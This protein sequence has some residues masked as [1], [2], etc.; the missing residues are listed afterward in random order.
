MTVTVTDNGKGQLEAKA[1]VTDAAFVNTY[2]ANQ[3]T[4]GS[5]DLKLSKQ[6][7][8]IAWPKARSSSR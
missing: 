4:V 8:G 3:V 5:T 7:T 6:L 2:K 1:E